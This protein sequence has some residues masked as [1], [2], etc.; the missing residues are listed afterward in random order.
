MIRTIFTFAFSTQQLVDIQTLEKIRQAVR[1]EHKINKCLV[2][3]GSLDSASRSSQLSGGSGVQIINTL[4]AAAD[5]VDKWF[6]RHS[7]FFD[8]SHITTIRQVLSEIMA[9]A[10]SVPLI[11]DPY[12]GEDDSQLFIKYWI[13]LMWL[14]WTCVRK[15]RMLQLCGFSVSTPYYNLYPP[16]RLLNRSPPIQYDSVEEQKLH[17]LSNLYSLPPYQLISSHLQDYP[18]PRQSLSSS[19]P[20]TPQQSVSSSIPSPPRQSLSHSYSFPSRRY[21]IVSEPD[22]ESVNQKNDTIFSAL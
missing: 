7:L 15:S 12:E 8:A 10:K 14:H 4:H 1:N 13:E 21:S 22:I 3:G 16:R 9:D 6:V 5:A 18:T 17:H 2:L 19:L 20:R 11:T